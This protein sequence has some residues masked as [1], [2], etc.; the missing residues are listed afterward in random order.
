MWKDT[1]VWFHLVKHRKNLRNFDNTVIK[2]GSHKKREIS[3]LT[4]ELVDFQEGLWS[5]YDML[6]LIFEIGISRIEVR[7]ANQ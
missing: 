7:S 1:V 3:Y 5:E 2:F 4:E 6:E